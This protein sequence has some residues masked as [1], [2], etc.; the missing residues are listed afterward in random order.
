MNRLSLV[1]HLK[2]EKDNSVQKHVWTSSLLA[3]SEESRSA[4]L[5][6]A[7]IDEKTQTT[8]N[9]FCRNRHL[10]TA[11]FIH[12]ECRFEVERQFFHFFGLPDYDASLFTSV[13]LSIRAITKPFARDGCTLLLEKRIAPRLGWVAHSLGLQIAT[14]DHENRDELR[15]QLIQHTS[16]QQVIVCTKAWRGNP[17]NPNPLHGTITLARQYGAKLLVDE[18][19][20]MPRCGPYGRGSCAEQGVLD[21]VD[22]LVFSLRH[23]FGLPGALVYAKRQWIEDDEYFSAAQTSRSRANFVTPRYV[24]QVRQGLEAS[25]HQ[26]DLA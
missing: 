15:Y 12:A 13:V 9:L 8:A 5:N 7:Q 11:R 18:S 24:E 10:F 21:D 2:T 22:W 3:T 6:Y 4:H 25:A 26:H 19:L 23:G 16:R 1:P 20:S 17:A 14:F